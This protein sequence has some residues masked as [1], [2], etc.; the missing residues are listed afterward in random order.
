MISNERSVLKVWNVIMYLFDVF[1]LVFFSRIHCN[2]V[3]FK[4]VAAT[5]YQ[6]HNLLVCVTYWLLTI[7]KL[8]DDKN[9]PYRYLFNA[10][11]SNAVGWAEHENFGAFRETAAGRYV[12]CGA[13]A[14]TL[15]AVIVATAEHRWRVIIIK[16]TSQF[17]M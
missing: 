1:F 13:A 10:D 4:P 11:D 5:R 2:T 16:I 6:N 14:G 9:I 17:E 3:S 12:L 7:T 15:R 8:C